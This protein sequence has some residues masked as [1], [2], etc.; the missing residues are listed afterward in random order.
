MAPVIDKKSPGVHQCQ[1]C[2][3]QWNTNGIH[4][5]LPFLEDIYE[6]TNVDVVCIQEMKLQPKDKTLNSETSVLPDVIDQ[7]RGKR[8][9]EPYDPYPKTDSLQNQPP[10]GQ[11]LKRDGET[12][13]LDPNLK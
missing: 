6:A 8:E 9:G 2:I 3:L 4:R 11:Q 12:D 5:E 13:D 10:T 1:L 7:C